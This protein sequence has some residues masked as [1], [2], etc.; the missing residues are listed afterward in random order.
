[1]SNGLIKQVCDKLSINKYEELHEKCVDEIKRIEVLPNER[2][3][4]CSVSKSCAGVIFSKE[5]SLINK[6]KYLMNLLNY[7]TLN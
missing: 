3:H 6:K 7:N 2:L 4:N 5:M 1:M